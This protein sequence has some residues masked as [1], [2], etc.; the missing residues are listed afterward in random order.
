MSS[1]VDEHISRFIEDEAIKIVINL[2]EEEEED[3]DGRDK[4]TRNN[5]NHP[6]DDW[7]TLTST[8]ITSRPK[9]ERPSCSI[10]LPL[11]VCRDPIDILILKKRIRM[12]TNGSRKLAD[13]DRIGK[14]SVA[15]NRHGRPLR[16]K[17][18]YG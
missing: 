5:H 15:G 17:N 18:G 8:C 1:I 4:T 7:S 9:V 10:W 12:E 6:A 3:V 11:S 16:D 13:T 2:A 14:I